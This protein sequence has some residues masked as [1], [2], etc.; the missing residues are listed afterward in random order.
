M[1][2]GLAGR[3]S[4]GILYLLSQHRGCKHDIA[5]PVFSHGLSGLDL[6][7]HD[8]SENTLLTAVSPTQQFLLEVL[9]PVFHSLHSACSQSGDS[10][11][12]IEPSFHGEAR[13]VSST[14]NALPHHLNLSKSCPSIKL[15]RLSLSPEALLHPRPKSRAVLGSGICYSVLFYHRVNTC[16]FLFLISIDA[17][18]V[19]GHWLAAVKQGVPGWSSR[20]DC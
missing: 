5:H 14:A 18:E 12:L 6:H 20:H 1:P 7:P 9:P 19:K 13:A 10:N 16:V 4:P 11:C 8:R 17:L 3:R 2:S 15:T